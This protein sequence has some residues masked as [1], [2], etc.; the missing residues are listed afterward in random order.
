M[1]HE[2]IDKEDPRC[3]YCNLECNIHLDGLPF[4]ASTGLSFNVEILNCRSCDET[5]EIYTEE[6]TVGEKTYTSFVFSCNGIVV[7]CDYDKET[8]LLGNKNMLWKNLNKKQA[9]ATTIP[10]FEIDFSNKKKLYKKLKT[11]VTFS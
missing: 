6:N 2:L 3:L 4:K 11:Y 7:L 1:L 5:F 8:F 9:K 10:S